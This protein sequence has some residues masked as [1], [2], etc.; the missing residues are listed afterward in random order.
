MRSTYIL[1][2]VIKI[3]QTQAFFAARRLT[4]AVPMPLC[5]KP[6]AQPNHRHAP[7]CGL[8]PKT[9]THKKAT[10]KKHVF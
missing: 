7:T 2:K 4:Q 9:Q 1:A 8:M 10:L 6:S 3:S 5:H